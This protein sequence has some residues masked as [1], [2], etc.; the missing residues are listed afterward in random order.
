[1]NA[2]AAVQKNWQAFIGLR[3]VGNHLGQEKFL[4][5]HEYLLL[6]FGLVSSFAVESLLH[7][8]LHPCVEA[9]CD[10][11]EDQLPRESFNTLKNN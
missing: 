9:A 5:C 1:M 2:F 11:P 8:F 3:R 10:R 4:S 7:T 6:N